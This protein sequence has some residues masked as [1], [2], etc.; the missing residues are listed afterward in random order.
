MTKHKTPPTASQIV[1]KVVRVDFHHGEAL[2]S[3]ASTYP[4]L[5]AVVLELIQNAL[6]AHANRIDIYCNF[7]ARNIQVNDNG[8]GVSEDDFNTALGLVCKSQKQ[9]GKL[10]RF[11]RGVISPLSIC[12]QYSLTSIAKGR[13][14]PYQQWTF[15]A[16]DLRRQEQ[17]LLIPCQA[18][19]HLEFDPSGRNPASV[20]W[21]TKLN[22]EGLTTDKLLTAM[23]MTDLVDAVLSR[24][25]KVMARLKTTIAVTLIDAQ[26]HQE[27]REFTAEEFQGEPL[28]VEQ[29]HHSDCGQVTFR[30]WLSRRVH[31]KKIGQVLL[32]ESHDEFR[33]PIAKLIRQT[34]LLSKP[35]ADALLSG[36]FEGE[37]VA[38]K[39]QLHPSREK[40]E[41]NDALVGFC[42]AIERWYH[43]IGQQYMQA[44]RESSRFERF[45]QVGLRA[46]TALDTLLR[47]PAFHI[48]KRIITTAKRGTIGPDHADV[49]DSK[50][51]PA[52]QPAVAISGGAGGHKTSTVKGEGRNPK[53]KS[54]RPDHMPMIV[55]G[56]PHSRQRRVVKKDS[57]GLGLV[58]D[59]MP[60]SSQLWVYEVDQATLRIN[61]RHPT[62]VRH[63]DNNKRLMRLVENIAI[64]ALSV[65]TLP[66]EWREVGDALA[67]VVID[68]LADIM[69][70]ADELAIPRPVTKKAAKVKHPRRTAATV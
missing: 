41:V 50:L 15:N 31:G 70:V 52:T 34:D 45:E 43:E 10:G 35:V 59:E 36:I 12:Q 25:R 37:I 11:G 9:T 14:R 20:S 65:E 1:G 38:P 18:Q 24:Y 21:R 39:I 44:E 48:L 69:Q 51:T 4:N 67:N 23:T 55:I 60:G 49:A 8:D 47:Q 56:G 33:L 46:L 16:A 32:G 13:I 66:V 58:Y 22:I 6:D 62:W 17:E 5:L 2:F 7:A 42:I 27:Q 3:I 40:L 57:L 19:R 63:E 64:L 29:I 54:D 68:P 30:L 26:K 61:V 28:P 53:P